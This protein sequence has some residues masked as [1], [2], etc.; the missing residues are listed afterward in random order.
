M[1]PGP[2]L[3]KT[4]LSEPNGLEFYHKLSDLEKENTELQPPLTLCLN[5]GRRLRS[6]SGIGTDSH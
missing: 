4:I 6:A 5:C 3:Q 1:C 2:V